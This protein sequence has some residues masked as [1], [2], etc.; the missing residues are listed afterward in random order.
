[1]H[2]RKLIVCNKS[3]V[4]I[5]KT[6]LIAFVMISSG[7][8][9]NLALNE[10]L[11]DDAEAYTINGDTI[12]WE[13][14]YGKMEV[15]PHTSIGL[16]KQTQ[17]CN[18]TVKDLIAGVP[19]DVAF[20]FDFL[21]S[22][23]DI[24]HQQSIENTYRIDN[25]SSYTVIG[26]PEYVNR[27]DIPSDYYA[28]VNTSRY[29]DS[30]Y[31]LYNVTGYTVITEP[32]ATDWGDVPSNT[33][34]N[35][36]VD[37]LSQYGFFDREERFHNLTGNTWYT[38]CGFDSYQQ[39]D[40]TTALFNYSYWSNNTI[41]CG[42][43]SYQQIGSDSYSMAYHYLD[44]ISVA[45]AFEHLTYGGKEYYYVT[46]VTF[47]ANIVQHFKWQYDVPMGSNGKWDFIVK[48]H[49]D[50][51]QEAFDSGRYVM[52]DPWWNS[53]WDYYK[54]CPI[55]GKIDDYQIKLIVGNSTGGN[56]TCNGH[57]KSDF[58][59]IRF[60]NTANDTEYP[61]WMENYTADTQATFWI[62]NTDN[63]STI[64]MYYGNS[65]ATTTSNGNNTFL[66]FDDFP[67]TSLD[68]D[69]WTHFESSAGTGDVTVGSGA[70]EV[71]Q[72][73]SVTPPG[74]EGI[75]SK[76]T[77]AQNVAVCF[78]RRE[79]GDD[80]GTTIPTGFSDMGIDNGLGDNYLLV[81]GV[82]YNRFETRN[83]GGTEDKNSIT[84]TWS[85]WHIGEV[86]WLSDEASYYHDDGTHVSSTTIPDTTP[87]L[88]A[89]ISARE[90][91]GGPAAKQEVD[92]ILVRKY[93]ST[94]PSWGTFGSWVSLQVT[95][96]TA[97]VSAS[98]VIY[99]TKTA[100]VDTNAILRTTKTADV[101][102]TAAFRLYGKTQEVSTSTVFYKARTAGLSTDVVLSTTKLANVDSTI[103]FWIEKSAGVDTTAVLSIQKTANV[104][105]SAVFTE[106]TP[107]TA[108]VDATIVLRAVKTA[109]VDA[110][111]ALLRT[112]AASVDATIALF[113]T[114]STDVNASAV[115][116]AVKTANINTTSVLSA[117]K[118]AEV[119]SDVAF[120]QIKTDT[121][122]TNAVFYK[123][124]SADVDATCVLFN[125]RTADVDATCVLFNERT[126]DVDASSVLHIQRTAE[127]PAT[128]SLF[129]QSIQRTASV[130]TTIHLQDLKEF[131]EAWNIIISLSASSYVDITKTEPHEVNIIKTKSF[132]VK[133]G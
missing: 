66:F 55:N 89:V 12:T 76:D 133:R 48:L 97:D 52:L 87:N 104:D 105:T 64:L 114:I 109:G 57:A 45:S 50:T 68:T 59:D 11:V 116:R 67:G 108:N 21:L 71:W 96:K 20:R 16:I 29:L 53:D 17:Y 31:T 125:E 19:I 99:T 38:I 63:A 6:L 73:H 130:D 32:N 86:R 44:W 95:T 106:V 123:S 103:S 78:R 126:A 88:S 54:T 15:Y 127:V 118:I 90:W 10:L 51:I 56:V 8:V 70:V 14:Q 92:W 62:N 61:Y 122:S 72:E 30:N 42:F 34:I 112:R 22:N 28:Q 129:A 81:H 111:A 46:D 25:V 4:N 100:N 2:L 79:T 119:S 35:V 120:R 47:P 65:S 84:K 36:T 9:V 93:A 124:L 40:A 7:I 58:G 121:V 107:E 131:R 24:W 3:Q 27:G 75:K 80:Y 115:L 5:A 18:L 110:T 69:K 91:W 60:V 128:A 74:C 37:N 98:T 83:D 43:D 39:L 132:D 85:S 13:N 94:E 1:M 82:W 41:L 102:T 113:K 26:E 49:S 117:K 33:Y 23:A 101:D 77:Y